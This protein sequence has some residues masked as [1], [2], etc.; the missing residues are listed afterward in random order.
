MVVLVVEVDKVTLL[1]LEFLV[2]EIMVEH[3]LLDT[4]VEVEEVLVLLEVDLKVET[5]HQII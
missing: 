3:L 1:E 5:V 2:K 4:L